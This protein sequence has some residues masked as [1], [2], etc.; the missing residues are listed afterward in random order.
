MA[1]R[2][3]KFLPSYFVTRRRF[4]Y[5]RGGWGFIIILQKSQSRQWGLAL[6]S[7]NYFENKRETSV[8]KLEI[9]IYIVRMVTLY[10]C[11]ITSVRHTL[12]LWYFA[13][14]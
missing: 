3:I 6:S 2:V 4:H 8:N 14:F 5:R 11:F 10:F 13:H 12:A 9:K 1:V 7:Q